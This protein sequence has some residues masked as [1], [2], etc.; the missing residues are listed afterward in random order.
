MVV[1]V[2]RARLIPA[3]YYSL[4]PTNAEVI[5][6]SLLEFTFSHKSH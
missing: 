2:H 6:A 4:V 1:G 5:L 3:F